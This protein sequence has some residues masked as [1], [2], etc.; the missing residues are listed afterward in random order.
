MQKKTQETAQQG[1]QWS[2][3]GQQETCWQ[4]QA[5]SQFVIVIQHK[6]MLP[7][8]TGQAALQPLVTASLP[9]NCTCSVLHAIGNHPGEGINSR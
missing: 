4:Q 5:K 9:S 1:Q 2:W 3:G 8:S 6:S 7:S